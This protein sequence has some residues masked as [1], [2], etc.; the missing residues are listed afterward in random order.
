M[1]AV[2]EEVRLCIPQKAHE[3]SNSLNPNMTQ[4]PV[5]NIFTQATMCSTVVSAA[6]LSMCVCDSDRTGAVAVAACRAFRV[7]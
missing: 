4:D 2:F 3:A 7:Y 6:L 5:I 1:G